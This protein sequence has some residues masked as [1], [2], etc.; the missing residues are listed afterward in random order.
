MRRMARLRDYGFYELRVP[1]WSTESK[2]LNWGSL[3]GYLYQGFE[4]GFLIGVPIGSVPYW[5]TY[6]NGSNIWVS[7]VRGFVKPRP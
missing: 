4:L 3:L 7:R 6:S 1:C 5:G 2:D